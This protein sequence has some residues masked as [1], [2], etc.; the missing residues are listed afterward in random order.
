MKRL[1]LVA[2]LVLVHA[3]LAA[4]AGAWGL[5]YLR[6]PNR[7]HT[8]TWVTQPVSQSELK[9]ADLGSLMPGWSQDT[10]THYIFCKGKQAIEITEFKDGIAIIGVLDPDRGQTWLFNRLPTIAGQSAAPVT[11]SRREITPSGTGKR[12]ESYLDQDGD[13]ILEI[14]L[15]VAA[16]MNSRS[17]RFRLKAD[18]WEP[19]PW[20]E[21]TDSDSPPVGK[22]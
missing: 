16:D 4:L 5:G 11:M 10:L 15:G 13:G 9:D 3:A 14:R 6:R 17:P 22:P 21:K 7:T 12:I 1:T 2:Y 8:L 19:W 20:P 18:A